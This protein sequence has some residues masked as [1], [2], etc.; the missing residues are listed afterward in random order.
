MAQFDPYRKW[1]GI[2]PEEQPPNHYR[3]L[4]IGLFEPDPDVISN[5][6][7]RQMAHVRT[8]Q[9]GQYSELSQRILNELSVARVSLLDETK[10]VAYDAELRATLAAIPVALPVLP[11]AATPPPPVESVP[12]PVFA[13]A[14][15][16]HLVP[17]GRSGFSPAPRSVAAY[18]ARRRKTSMQGPLVAVALVMACLGLAAWLLSSSSE[19]EVPRHSDG[20]QATQRKPSTPSK[21]FRPVPE[22]PSK[23]KPPQVRPKP[24]LVADRPSASSEAARSPDE[25]AGKIASEAPKKPDETSPA[26]TAK[27]AAPRPE[28][29]AVPGDEAAR[30]AERLIRD[31]VF[32]ADFEA[33]DRP[34]KKVALAQRLIEEAGKSQDNPAAAY[35]MLRLARDEAVAGGDVETALAA[36]ETLGKRYEVDEGG[37]KCETLESLARSPA[38][39]TSAKVLVDKMLGAVDGSVDG[40]DF[41][42]AERLLALS[43]TVAAKARDPLLTKLVNARAKRLQGMKQQYAAVAEAQKVLEAAANDPQANETVGKYDCLARGDWDRGLPKLALAADPDLRAQAKAD[44]AAP[45]D[46]ANR[47]AVADGWWS[48]AEKHSGPAQEQLRKRAATWYKMTLVDLSGLN[49]T[50]VEQRLAEIGAEEPSGDTG[51]VGNSG[52]PSLPKLTG[53]ECRDAA[54]RPALLKRYGGNDASEAAVDRA[55]LWLEKHQNA[56][57]SWSFDHHGPRC[58]NLCPNPG[59]LESAPNAATALALLSFLGTGNGPREGKFRKSVSQGLNYL[60]GRMVPLGIT[61]A[62]FE[63]NSQHMPSHAW[64]TIAL[65]EAGAGIRERQLHAAAQAAVTF[66]VAT[67]NSDGGWSEKPNLPDFGKKSSSGV[68]TLEP[69]TMAATGWNMAALRTAQW[70][71]LMV[72]EKNMMQAAAFLDKL[73]V[74]NK[75]PASGKAISTGYRCGISYES[76]DAEATAIGMCLRTYLGAARQRPELAGYAA[77]LD[78]P[79]LPSGGKLVSHYFQSELLR[80]LEAPAWPEWNAALRDQLISAQCRD[81]HAIG[82]WYFNDEGWAC[83]QGG[84]LFCTAMSALILEVYYRHPPQ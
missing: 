18:A 14:E 17:P 26:P 78:K 59:K 21:P 53:L 10:R 70:V 24:D 40:A 34:S 8:F 75:A 45:A 20:G 28:R 31:E 36:A 32:K 27:P 65:C 46:G 84:R 29:I 4:G 80:Q 1:L 74:E 61:A 77:T 48:L 67:Q 82:S 15:I 5:A 33:A 83:Q 25:A 58:K 55:L 79:G 76:L 63:P 22:R 68:K 71:A 73:Y 60:K 35:V 47:L 49:R 3:L 2:P 81:G 44:L 9:S 37:M 6:A 7:D 42:A 23:P 56:D 51:A 62:L 72:P 66:I 30:E 16:P 38:A 11:T 57:G 19:V 69:S 13:D 52:A 41:A 12:P 43:R 50:K 64:G 54:V 39:T